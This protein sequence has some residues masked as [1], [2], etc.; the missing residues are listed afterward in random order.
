VLALISSEEKKT[1]AEYEKAKLGYAD[2][3]KKAVNAP[4]RT[5]RYVDFK[6]ALMTTRVADESADDENWGALA[7][8][9]VKAWSGFLADYKTGW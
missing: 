8:E 6:L 7:A 2:L 9:A 5:K 4:E 1:K 3:Q